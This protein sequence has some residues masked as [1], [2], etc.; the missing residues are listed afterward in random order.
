MEITTE[1]VYANGSDDSHCLY[2]T[3]PLTTVPVV[4]I[5]A[6]QISGPV[7]Y[8]IAGFQ[9][10]ATQQWDEVANPPAFKEI[11][12]T[13]NSVAEPPKMISFL[14]PI[15]TPQTNV[16]HN[17]FLYVSMEGTF[18]EGV[19]I[20]FLDEVYTLETTTAAYTGEGVPIDDDR[21]VTFARNT[22]DTPITLKVIYGVYT[23]FIDDPIST[24]SAVTTTKPPTTTTTTTTS[25]TT[26]TSSTTKP[27]TPAGKP[28]ITVN[29]DTS[30]SVG[31]SP[32]G[33]SGDGSS[34]GDGDGDGEVEVQVNSQFE[35]LG[36][37]SWPDSWEVSQ[38]VQVFD[39]RPVPSSSYAANVNMGETNN[40]TDT[41]VQLT[42]YTLGDSSM[43]F[44]LDISSSEDLVFDT[45]FINW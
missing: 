1:L 39:D 31:T 2:C 30:F 16:P 24:T 32:S 42:Y 41:D 15:E 35:S 18:Q 38:S 19:V 5:T 28:T 34:G 22:G 17:V 36:N 40:E 8:N 44:S 25:T 4:D 21:A 27:A 33:G 11:S 37:S 23:A 3:G 43:K 10:P 13:L 6:P 45:D 7:T 9:I 20:V 12:F 29:T 26:S 14:E